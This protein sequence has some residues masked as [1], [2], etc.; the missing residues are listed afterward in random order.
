MR[1]DVYVAHRF[2]LYSRTGAANAIRSGEVVSTSRTLKPASLLKAGEVL[3]IHSPKLAPPREKPPCPPVLHADA[4]ILAFNKPAGMLCH[5]VG[6]AFAWGV[7][8]LARDQYPG[9]PLH[10]AHR[11]DR[12]TSGVL[13]L[14]RTD[15]A[16]RHLKAQFKERSV[17]KTYLAVVRGRVAWETQEVDAPIGDDADSP[18]RLKQSVR[19]DGQ[20]ARTRFV[21]KERQGDRTLVE[22]HPH[23]GRTHQI[24]VHLS[25]LGHPIVGDKIYGQP[26]EVFLSL[27]EGWDLPGRDGLLEHPRHCLHAASLQLTAPD[28]DTL[29]IHAPFPDDMRTAM[30]SRTPRV[31]GTI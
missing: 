19:P 31:G 5:P 10:L 7:I 26:P 29:F 24:R 9:E 3:H 15:V 25:H 4:H 27:F 8:N 1:A 17:E 11:L 28:G 14:G 30:D 16:N 2:A 6:M 18:I 21:V 12:E 13:L 20:P 22:V 23:T